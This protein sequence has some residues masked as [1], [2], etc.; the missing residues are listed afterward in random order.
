METAEITANQRDITLEEMVQIVRG[1]PQTRRVKFL[2]KVKEIIDSEPTPK[3]V[4]TEGSASLN[5]IWASLPQNMPQVSDEEID[6]MK[7]GWRMEKYS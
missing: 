5:K 2:R 6:E 4:E 1:W 3:K 7:L